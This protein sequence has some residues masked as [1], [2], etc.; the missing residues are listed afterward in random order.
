MSKSPKSAPESTKLLSVEQIQAEIHRARDLARAA[1]PEALAG[2]VDKLTVGSNLLQSMG[3]IELVAWED[4]LSVPESCACAFALSAMLY[5]ELPL[6]DWDALE[7]H[8]R[9]RVAARRAFLQK[10][11]S[12]SSPNNDT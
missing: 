6:S 7:D 10:M 11:S 5:R 2:I 8:I 1:L 12:E 3:Q 9:D 4:H